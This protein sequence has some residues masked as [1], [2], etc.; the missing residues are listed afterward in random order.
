M[1]SGHRASP[2]PHK[3]AAGM[4]RGT[5]QCKQLFLP[6]PDTVP[7]AK[8][9]QT[10]PLPV[11]MGPWKVGPHTPCVSP[12]P[13]CM[14]GTGR[15]AKPVLRGQE[16]CPAGSEAGRAQEAR[17]PCPLPMGICLSPAQTPPG[18]FSLSLFA[19]PWPS[20][21]LLFPVAVCQAVTAVPKSHTL[22]LS[23][24]CQ[25]SQAG[26]VGRG[27]HKGCK[28][29]GGHGR[30]RWEAA[31]RGLATALGT[32]L[33]EGAERERRSTCASGRTLPKPGAVAGEESVSH[34][35]PGSSP[36]PFPR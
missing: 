31:L 12:F 34:S 3:Q 17:H 14:W 22:L 25:C 10:N 20:C 24:P 33:E 16:S 5:L 6:S 32:H 35:P 19:A 4:H 28:G 15:G 11:P 23:L 18:C 2:R 30:A 13:V 7:A 29:G 21:A 36:S 1:G 8:M 9:A 27:R 26:R